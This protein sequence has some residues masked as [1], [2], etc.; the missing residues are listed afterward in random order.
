MKSRREV[1]FSAAGLG[2]GALMVATA[3]QARTLSASLSP[4]LMG[5]GE[6]YVTVSVS[7]GIGPYSYQW[8]RISGSSD[9]EAT[10]PNGAA[11][12]F[13]WVGPWNGPARLSNWVCQVTDSTNETVSTGSVHVGYGGA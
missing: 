2:V 4:S 12:E 7:G 5:V 10:D 11:T 6:G 9:I 1:M 8:V 3:A 13:Q